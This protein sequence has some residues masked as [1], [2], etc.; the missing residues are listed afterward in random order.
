MY[1][2]GDF[3]GTE[4]EYVPGF[5]THV[6][7]SGIYATLVGEKVVDQDRKVSIKPAALVPALMGRGSIVVGVIDEIFEPVALVRVADIKG[8][9]RRRTHNEYYC[10]LHASRVRNGFVKTIRTE[11]RIGDIIRAIVDDVDNGETYLSTKGNEYGV[12][13]AFCSRCRHGMDQK[14][15]RVVCPKCGSAETRKIAE[16]YGS[17]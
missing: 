15:S 9:E 5:G 6:E 17:A 7:G 3:L 10:V 14:G 16:G 4:E 8:G 2:P 12:I 1:V 13:R 11:V